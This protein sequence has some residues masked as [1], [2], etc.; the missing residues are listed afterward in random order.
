[1]LHQIR[2]MIGILMAISRGFVTADYINKAFLANESLHLPVAPGLGLLLEQ[3]ST[4]IPKKIF[5]E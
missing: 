3:V 2:K 4:C 1:M 5:F